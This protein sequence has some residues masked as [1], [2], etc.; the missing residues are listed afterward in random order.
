MKD[1]K[2]YRPSQLDLRNIPKMYPGIALLLSSATM[3]VRLMR[4]G[5][6]WY[7]IPDATK[8]M[9]PADRKNL[10]ITRMNAND[11]PTARLIVASHIQVS[12]HLLLLSFCVAQWL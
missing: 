11:M 9:G 2:T 1:S 6:K 12:P 4:E 10:L 8:V 3:T 7:G 5:I